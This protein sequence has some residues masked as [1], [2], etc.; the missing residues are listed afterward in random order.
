MTSSTTTVPAL[1]FGANTEQGRAVVEG[2]VDTGRY[3]PVYVFTR[4]TDP[5]VIHYL[6]DGLGGT[7]VVNSSGSGSGNYGDLENPDHVTRALLETRAPA[8]FLATD[9]A[10]RECQVILLFFEW[11]V[12]AYQKDHVA[13]HV[14]FVT[15]EN[16]QEIN[17]QVLEETGELWIAPLEDG[18]IVPHFTAKAKGAA[19]AMAALE[20][21]RPDLQLTLVTMPFLYSNFLGFFTPLPDETGTQWNLCACFGDGAN[22]ID[23]MGSADLGRIVRKYNSGDHFNNFDCANTYSRHTRSLHNHSQH[24][25]GTGKICGTEPS[26]GRGT[27]IHGP[28]RRRFFGFVWQG[29]HL[30]SLDRG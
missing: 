30:Q 20:P 8:I 2:L 15:A 5:E 9:A 3:D 16:V 19:Q 13:R 29:R 4:E 14:V 27:H 11:L 18:S 6:T 26:F 21:Y 25:C 24:F 17:L 23:M 28:S 1:V 7:L 22:Q 10:E 12:L